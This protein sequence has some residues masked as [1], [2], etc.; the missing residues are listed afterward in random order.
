MLDLQHYRH[1]LFIYVFTMFIYCFFANTLKGVLEYKTMA[2]KW[3][4]MIQKEKG[5]EGED[6]SKQI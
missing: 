5:L 3:I 6:K 1:I 2:Y 4:D